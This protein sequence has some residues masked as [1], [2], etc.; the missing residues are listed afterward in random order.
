[1]DI[2]WGESWEWAL[3]LRCKKPEKGAMDSL[4][5]TPARGIRIVA[6]TASEIM[7]GV[8]NSSPQPFVTAV[9]PSQHS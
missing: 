2:L 3:A 7:P 9:V 8:R 6:D 5:V 1:M 4:D